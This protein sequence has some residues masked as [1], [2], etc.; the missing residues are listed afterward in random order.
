MNIFY[1]RS[2]RTD[3][4]IEWGSYQEIAIQFPA[5][6]TI[7]SKGGK[8]RVFCLSVC[9]GDFIVISRG[10]GPKLNVSFFSQ[11]WK[12]QMFLIMQV[13]QRGGDEGACIGIECDDIGIIMCRHQ[14]HWSLHSNLQ[15]I[16]DIT[17]RLTLSETVSAMGIVDELSVLN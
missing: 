16:M 13:E 3:Y 7:T 11:F 6:N 14:Q 17:R 15:L 5:R 8:K 9:E 12:I 1:A 2:I 10:D 4:E